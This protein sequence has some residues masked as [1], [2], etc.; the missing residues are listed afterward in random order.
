MYQ[1]T[2]G[3]NVG[4]L[5][6][7]KVCVYNGRKYYQSQTW[8]VGCDLE[9]ICDDAGVGLY[10]CQSRCANYGTLPANCKL[11][12]P[13]GECFAKPECEFNT[14]VGHFT[15]KGQPSG[16]GDNGFKTTPPPCVDKL[17]NCASFDAASCTSDSYGPWA[18]EN[19]RKTCNLCNAGGVP[20]PDDRCVY[21]GNAYKQGQS[22][23]D[24]CEKICVC[25]N[26]S[27]GYYRCDNQCP[28]YYNMPPGCA[29]VPMAGQCRK[30]MRCDTGTITGS[31]TI[32][33]TIGAVPVPFTYPTIRPGI[34]PGMTLAPGMTLPP[35]LTPAPGMT[36]A[37]GFVP[38]QTLAPGVTIPWWFTPAPGRTYAPTPF[39]TPAPLVP[40][41]TLPPGQ[42]IPPYITPAPGMTFAPGIRPGMTLAPG[43]TVPMYLTPRPGQT[44]APQVTTPYA[45]PVPGYTF[46][47]G[48]VPGQTLAPGMTVPVYLTP[49]PG[50]TYAPGWTPAR[51]PYPLVP[52]VTLPYGQTIP[53][54]ITP[55]PGM[56]FAPGIRPGQTL[57]P[58]V[59]VPIYLTPAP[60]RTYAPGVT[61]P[62]VPLVPGITLPPGQTIPSYITPP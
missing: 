13:P 45:T 35:Y 24:G 16:P 7:N 38:G 18:L 33:G 46:G 2:T 22:W 62:Q 3:Q 20:G 61:R 43:V 6:G 27:F 60:G 23:Q 37:P 4:D 48:I 52:G 28:E 40:G 57:A 41:M 11:V 42:T 34:V 59:T 53:S 17:S 29:L 5:N 9:C 1:T 25:E 26:A 8:T 54:Y 50:R 58:G 47:P 49:A 12:K 55:A 21:K 56:S 39:T 14:Q 30:A 51:T 36:L 19:C 44:Y 32:P 10:S 31:Q 15:G